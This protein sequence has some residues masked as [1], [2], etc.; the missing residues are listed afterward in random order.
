MEEPPTEHLALTCFPNSEQVDIVPLTDVEAERSKG[1]SVCLRDPVRQHR[2]SVYTVANV[3]YFVAQ[4]VCM[5]SSCVFQMSLS[6]PYH[7]RSS[8]GNTLGIAISA[9]ASGGH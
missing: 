3:G 2:G 8:S 6:I 9:L 4:L 7:T 1:H 5:R